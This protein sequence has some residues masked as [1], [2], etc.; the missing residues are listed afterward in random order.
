MKRVLLFLLLHFLF[1]NEAVFAQD[2]NHNV[3]YSNLALQFSAQ[4]FNGDAGT[5]MLPSVAS[6]NGFGSYVDNPASVALIKDNYFSFSLLNNRV[7]YENT[8]LNNTLNTSENSTKP[9]NIGFV[10]KLPTKQGSFVMGGGYNRILNQEGI[11]RLSARNNESTLTDAFKDPQSDY[12]DIAY[13]AYAIDWGD[14]DSTYLES[15]FR[16]GFETYPGITQ[17]AEISYQTNIGEYSFFFGTEFQKNFFVG[18]SGSLTAGS[19]F[20]SR[21]FLEIDD[22]GDYDYSFIPS[23]ASDDSTDIDYILTY[24]EID[25]DITGFTFRTGLIYKITPNLNIGLS[26]ELPSTIVVREGYYSSIDTEF[27]DG[28]SP[29]SLY[30]T[31]FGSETDFEYRIQKPAQLKAGFAVT[32]IGG[33]DISVSGE[34]IDYSNL[35][36]DLVEGNNLDFNDEVALREQQD[37]LDDFMADSYKKVINYKAGLAFAVTEQIKVKAGYAYLQGKS[38]IYEADRNVFSGGIGVH[39]TKDI[40]LDVNGQY[41]SWNDRSIAYSYYDNNGASQSETILQEVNNLKILAGIR[42][43]F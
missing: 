11:N 37:L 36:L 20:Y 3:T 34:L 39:I 43:L 12:Y 31:S 17:D 35:R 18:I 8:Y 24:D 32:N 26:Y 22:R 15:I 7:E 40:V 13:N 41:L 23:P 16:I 33:F 30:D 42:F 4:N 6:A 14:V 28:S 38:K 5:G 9:G 25:A 1:L 29:S 10:Y 2:G 19:Y 21:D 27:D